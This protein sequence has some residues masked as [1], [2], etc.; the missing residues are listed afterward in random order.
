MR[1]FKEM[2]GHGL[3]L[4]REMRGNS[5]V[6][7]YRVPIRK[8]GSSRLSRLILGPIWLAGCIIRIG[9]FDRASHLLHFFTS[10][11]SR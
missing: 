4:V 11:N 3:L 2:C 8:E 1:E 9:T 5:L 6:D 7:A 10:D